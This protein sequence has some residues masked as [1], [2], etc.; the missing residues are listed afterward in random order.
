MRL[1]LLQFYDTI[2]NSFWFV[3]TV[4]AVGALFLVWGSITLDRNLEGESVRELFWIWSGS[5][6]GA[7]SVLAA[8]AGSVM[9]VVS[10]VFSVTVTALAM[11]SSQY[12]PRILR[13]FTSD[14]GNQITLGTFI[15][16]FIYSLLVLRTVRS[17]EESPFVPDISVTICVLLA[18]ASLA[19]LIY[20]IHHVSRS[21]QAEHLIAGVGQEFKD[22]LPLV[23][24][25]RI[26]QGVDEDEPTLDDVHLPLRR[27]EAQDI[28]STHTGYIQRVDH[29]RLMEV[30]CDCDVTVRL[31][32][33]PGD[34]VFEG[35]RVMQAWPAT[36]LNTQAQTRLRQCLSIGADR[37]PNQDLRYPLQQL[38]EIAVLALSPGINKT[39]T[40]MICIDW[41]GASLS[42]VM[43]RA[44]PSSL[45]MDEEGTLRVIAP[46]L[47]FE[48]I[49]AETF[50][51]IRL[52]GHTNGYILG[53]L[54]ETINE[55]VPHLQRES[56]R[57]VL[58][59]H[60]RQIGADA[61]LIVNADDRARVLA[62]VQQTLYQLESH[63]EATQAEPQFA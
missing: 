16:T 36:R 39:F 15:A 8:V 7:R 58:I 46:S 60:V 9:T 4:M 42:G 26:G 59:G 1:R 31:E 45:R 38:V 51:Q 53:Y 14:R 24:P 25:E 52:Y 54:L 50:D 62:Q 18:L 30:A 28:F 17:V 63:R 10:I 22:V 19:V 37:T 11:M 57:Q 43:G 41:L 48:E 6:S 61:E 49:A 34:F 56:D 21:I 23:F 35:V 29:A 2:T 13:N 12:G 55:L 27:G 20:F 44:I 40:A 33:R 5:A 47:S 3:P 32:K